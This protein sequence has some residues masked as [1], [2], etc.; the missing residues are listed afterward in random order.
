MTWTL[1]DILGLVLETIRNPREGAS[2]LLNM[3]PQRG[4]LWQMLALVVVLSV[5]LA[6]GTALLFAGSSGQAVTGP[7]QVSPMATGFIQ[8]GLLVIMVYAT[9]WIGRSFG[10]TG[11]FEETLLLVTWLQ[12]VL[13]CLQ[14]AQTA[15]LLVLP[16]FA[17]LIG[18]AA[19]I[20]FFWLLVNFV[21]VL[22][23]FVSLGMVF[24]GIILSAFGIAFGL[25]LILTL[26]GITVPGVGD[27]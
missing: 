19:L 16:P 6:H 4:V 1:K 27:V 20:L 21:A 24:L 14:V 13:V 15:A 10:G 17:G 5:L 22:H 2:T 8:G 26:I 3:T 25:S 9:F 23:G 7:F 18:I 11:S 12:F